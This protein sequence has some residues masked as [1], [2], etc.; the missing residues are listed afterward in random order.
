[1][2]L[3]VAPGRHGGVVVSA[4]RQLHPW[5]HAELADDFSTAICGESYGGGPTKTRM[6]GVDGAPAD[7][8]TAYEVLKVVRWHVSYHGST[9]KPGDH[10][11]TELSLYAVLKLRA[12]YW[13]SVVA[14]NDYT[15]WGCQDFA[16]VRI[17][18]SEDEVVR[19]G[20]DVEGRSLLK[21]AGGES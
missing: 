20:L 3:F 9:W 6:V 19:H 7:R 10:T 21:Y 2:A 4:D 1:M 15:G 11:G 17:G 16:D 18:R 5:P 12:G 13:A 8:V 14:G